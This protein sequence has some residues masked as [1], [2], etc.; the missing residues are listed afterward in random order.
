MGLINIQCP[1]F[2]FTFSQIRFKVIPLYPNLLWSSINSDDF[3]PLV[4]DKNPLRPTS[5]GQKG[6]RPFAYPANSSHYSYDL[7]GNTLKVDDPDPRV[8]LPTVLAVR[9]FFQRLRKPR[10]CLSPRTQHSVGA[11]S[12]LASSSLMV[13]N[14]STRK[15]V[16]SSAIRLAQR[17]IWIEGVHAP[18]NFI[19]FGT[20]LPVG[21]IRDRPQPIIPRPLFAARPVNAGCFSPVHHDVVIPVHRARIFI[22]EQ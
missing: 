7:P 4:E 19:F 6:P 16:I 8:G 22:P 3:M 14:R 15:S 10:K 5:G 1:V 21:L 12:A 11:P 18:S 20:R 9:V 13:F 2:R 17:G